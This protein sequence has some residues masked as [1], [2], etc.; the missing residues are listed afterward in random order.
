MTALDKLA[1]L[2]AAAVPCSMAVYYY[3]LHPATNEDDETF[4]RHPLFLSIAYGFLLVEAALVFRTSSAKRTTKETLHVVLHGC[5]LICAYVGLYAIY[6]LKVKYEKSHLQTWHS[7]AG[8]AVAAMSTLQ[9]FSALMQSPQGRDQVKLHKWSGAGVILLSAVAFAS[10]FKSMLG[11]VLFPVAA[12]V[13][14][15]A[16]AQPRHGGSSSS[17]SSTAKK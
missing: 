7:Y 3:V 10:G 1:H 12:L 14:I 13:T 16:L 15:I 2:A 8:A 17:V 5:A 4:R 11:M 9:F 6:T